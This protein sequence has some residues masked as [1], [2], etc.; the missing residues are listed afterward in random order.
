LHGTPGSSPR[1]DSIRP[2][3]IRAGA[4]YTADGNMRDEVTCGTAGGGVRAGTG[5]GTPHNICFG[6]VSPGARHT[7]RAE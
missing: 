2:G 7:P 4:E 5:Y 1:P 3:R 6:I